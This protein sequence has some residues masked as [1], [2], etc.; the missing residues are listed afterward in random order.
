MEFLHATLDSIDNISHKINDQ[1]YRE[2][3]DHLHKWY[4]HT[5]DQPDILDD[6]EDPNDLFADGWI[7]E[8]G[9]AL[10][11]LTLHES[12]I[13][14]DTR[15]VDEFMVEGIAYGINNRS[16][17]DQ[18]YIFEG[19]SASGRSI[20]FKNSRTLRSH[21]LLLGSHVSMWSKVLV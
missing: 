21:S 12:L 1:E 11:E 4:Q 13:L 3:V 15:W 20:S 5:K 8:H 10:P 6:F 2:I 16:D 9:F 14:A 7:A 17:G 19:Y 18:I